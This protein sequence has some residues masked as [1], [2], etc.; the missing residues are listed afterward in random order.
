MPP[1]LCTIEIFR[2]NLLHKRAW[3]GLWF[4]GKH[5]VVEAAYA[6]RPLIGY[7]SIIDYVLTDRIQLVDAIGDNILEILIGKRIFRYF[8]VQ[9]LQLIKNSTA[10]RRSRPPCLKAGLQPA[11]W[12]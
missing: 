11:D 3:L 8:A 6:V 4:V 12:C 7:A 1:F 9:L 10:P 5:R 2:L